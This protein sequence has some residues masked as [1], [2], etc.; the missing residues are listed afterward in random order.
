MEYDQKALRDRIAAL[1]QEHKQLDETISEIVAEPPFNQ[2]EV[3]RL[4]KRKLQLRD[5]I[6]RLEDL[7][8]PDI[9]A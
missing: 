8:I 1:M 5:E 9:I 7:L 6:I 2:I 3:Q 4:K